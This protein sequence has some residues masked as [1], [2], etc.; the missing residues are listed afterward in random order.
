MQDLRFPDAKT[1]AQQ[2]AGDLANR[3]RKCIAQNGHVSVALSGGK[4]P[5]LFMQ[6]LAQEKMDWDNVLI[7]QVDERWVDDQNDASNAKLIRQHLLQ[8]AAADAYFLPL[9]NTAKSP[10]YGFMESENRLQEQIAQLDYAVLGMGLDGHTAS[11]FPHSKA[12]A[13]IL[14]EQSNARCAPV[15]DAPEFAQ[16]MTLTWR[17]LSQCR[18][19]FVHME[20]NAKDV[21]L[22]QALLSERAHDIEAMPIRKILMQS[23]VPVTIYRTF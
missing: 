4:T 22:T 10:V 1:L 15:I 19:L 8:G 16:R 9:K 11:W 2:L 7:T 17:F 20:G 5:V 12:L 14:N 18:H 13:A 6:A 21:V 23:Q 3:M